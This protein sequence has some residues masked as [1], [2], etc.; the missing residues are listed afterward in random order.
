MQADGASPGQRYRVDVPG[1][2][3]HVTRRDDGHLLLRGPAV[4]VAEGVA[5]RSGLG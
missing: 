2:T 4:V 3:L 1:G 5:Y